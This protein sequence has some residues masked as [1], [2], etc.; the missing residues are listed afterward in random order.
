MEKKDQSQAR[1]LTQLNE[2]QRNL[3]EAERDRDK[4]SNQLEDALLKLQDYGR[5]DVLLVLR[6]GLGAMI[7]VSILMIPV[8]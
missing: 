7:R 2:M 5:L 6:L 1:L 3:Q 4:I 8:H